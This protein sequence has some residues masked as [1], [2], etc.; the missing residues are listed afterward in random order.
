MKLHFRKW[1]TRMLP[2]AVV[3]MFSLKALAEGEVTD[4]TTGIGRIEGNVDKEIF[5]VVLPADTSGVFDFVIDPQGLAYKTNGA[6]YGGKKF[7]D[8]ASLYFRRSDGETE[9]DYHSTSD[10]VTIVNNSSVPVQVILT[11]SIEPS[12][13]SG[14]G[15]TQDREFTD[16]TSASLYLAL[17]DGENT[18]ALKDGEGASIQV[19][20]PAAPEEAFEYYYDSEHGQYAYRLKDDLSGIIF[21]EYSFRLT[22]ASNG[23]GNWSSVADAAPRVTVKWTVTP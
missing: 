14:I 6:A 9:F 17:T 23:K 11:A 10:A 15:L 20:I 4:S 18:V 19:T 12:S 22:G 16:D 1:I 13:E 5:Q 3:F 21:P 7:E 8:N 2:L